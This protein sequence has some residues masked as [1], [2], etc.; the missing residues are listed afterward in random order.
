M[1]LSII[2][3]SLN[4]RN[5]KNAF[6]NQRFTGIAL[7]KDET[8]FL[9]YAFQFFFKSFPLIFNVLLIKRYASQQVAG[10]PV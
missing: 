5:V 10:I 2:L 4:I 6:R 8:E 7:Q 3:C 9:I 1:P